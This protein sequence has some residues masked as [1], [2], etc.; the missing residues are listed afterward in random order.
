MDTSSRT[1]VALVT[2]LC[3]PRFGMTPESVPM[4]PDLDA[5]LAHADAALIIGDNALFLDPQPA[6]TRR[7]ISVSCGPTRPACRSSTRSGRA[8]RMR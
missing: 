5:M 8:G 4:A 3:A 6:G 2:V 1:S 7:S